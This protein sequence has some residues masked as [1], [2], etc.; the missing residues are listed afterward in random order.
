MHILLSLVLAFT[1]VMAAPRSSHRIVGG[2]ITNIN[3]YPDMV[4]VLLKFRDNWFRHWCGGVILNNRSILTAAH[5][6][7]VLTTSSWQI[8]AGSTYADSYGVVYAVSAIINHQ[9]YNRIT[10]DNDIG[11]L[12]VVGSIQYT[13]VIQPAS[14]AGANYQL[15]DNQVVW[16]AGWGAT[17]PGGSGSDQLR[18][19]QIWT[20]NQ[21]VCRE[22]YAELRLILTDNM[23]CS[24]WLDVGVRDQCQGD[25]GGPLYHNRVVVGLSSWG[26]SCALPRYPGVNTRVSRYTSWIQANA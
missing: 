16:A 10:I 26:K 17:A 24:G 1:A 20:V 2:S 6:F 25:S 8:R 22:R 19:V 5:C 9:Q 18:H 7:V 4:A 15:A 12:R 13:N 14:I 23:L 11:I 3:S 21:A